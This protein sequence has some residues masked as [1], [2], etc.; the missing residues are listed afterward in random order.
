MSPTQRIKDCKLN[1][2]A[3]LLL[4]ST[5]SVKEII[6]KVGITNKTYFYN[7]FANKYNMSPKQYKDSNMKNLD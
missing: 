5:M 3:K 2:A 4:T 6:Y 1:Y 7:E